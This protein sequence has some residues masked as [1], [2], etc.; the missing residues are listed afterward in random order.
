MGGNGP[1]IVLDDADITAATRAT[2]LGCF[3]NAG[4]VCSSSERILVAEQLYDE[5]TERMVAAAQEV[6]LGNPFER[7]TTMGPLN[8]PE[9]AGKFQHHV[10][11]GLERG[12]TV[13][14]GGKCREDLG[15][16]LFYEPTVLT[17]VSLESLLNLEET[18]G[19]VVPLIRVKDDQE[20]LRIAN[21]NTL[22]LV[23]SVFTRDL[24]RAF[25]FAEGI[26]SGIVNVND[27]SNY[28]ELHIPFGGVAGKRSGIGRIGGT[29]SLMEMTDQKTICID[30]S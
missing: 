12:A 30:M 3:T 8:N 17:D 9:V 27:T 10:A 22:G 29:H 24:K 14:F 15:S 26:R 2:A 19:P 4:Q 1:V 7:D 13:L 6:K 25:Y 21:R 23:S 16:P 11:D 5:F 28:W 18:F 20:I